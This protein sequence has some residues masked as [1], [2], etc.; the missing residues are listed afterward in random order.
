ML[1]LQYI[2]T[3]KN[4]TKIYYDWNCPR[5]G[6]AGEADKWYYTGK[7][8]YACGGTGKRAKPLTVKEYTPE[9]EAKL[10]ARRQARLAKELAKNPPPSEE[11][12]RA[13]ATES[14]RNQFETLGLTREGIGYVYDGKGTYKAKDTI[15]ANGGRW[16]GHVWV[17]P[18]RMS[19]PNVD[20][21]E[22]DATG[23]VNEYRTVELGLAID[24]AI[25]HTKHQ[26]KAERVAAIKSLLAEGSI[27]EDEAIEQAIEL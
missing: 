5:C 27:T 18:V 8:C 19:F 6:G 4:G 17:A 21:Y 9:Y 22:I 11:E 10:E 20:V 1:E 16:A 26:Q 24:D 25:F 7:I 23:Y 3:D 15:K 14:L 13:K 12:L 2:R